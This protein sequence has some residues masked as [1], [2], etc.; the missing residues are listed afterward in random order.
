MSNRTQAKTRQHEVET[1][2]AAKY[3]L[4]RA[5]SVNTRTS[6]HDQR[7]YYCNSDVDIVF[8][9]ISRKYTEPRHLHTE[10]TEVY[11]VIRGAL[12]MEIEEESLHLNAGDMLVVPPNACHSFRTTDEEV[13][14]L[15]I[16]RFPLLKD[17]KP[18]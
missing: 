3:T 11:F 1:A 15:A 2:A 13:C 8:T 9:T 4:L 12:I 7:L 14:F 10:N 6:E 5:D 17:K 18:C 16:K